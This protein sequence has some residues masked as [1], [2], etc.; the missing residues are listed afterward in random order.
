MSKGEREKERRVELPRKEGRRKSYVQ[1]A[2][3]VWLGA[4]GDRCHVSYM[5]QNKERREVH[6]PLPLTAAP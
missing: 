6:P 1:S 4:V 2:D 5:V 3:D